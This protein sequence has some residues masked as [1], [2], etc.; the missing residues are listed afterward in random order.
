M[1]ENT[2]KDEMY[3]RRC[4]ELAEHGMGQV[5]PNPMVGSVIVCEDRIIGEGYHRLYG[6]PHAEVNAIES[7]K[8]KNLLKR[9]TL[10]VNLEP[11]AHHGKTPP[12]SVLIQQM[13][14]PR[15]VIGSVDSNPQVAGKG[16]ERLTKEGCNVTTGILEKESRRL[17]KRFYTFHEK[18]RPYIILKWAQTLDGLIDVIRTPGNPAQPTWITNDVCRVLVHKWRSEEMA[19]LAG[20]NTVEKDNP[21]LTVRHWSGN[22]PV[23]VIID[24]SLRLPLSLKVFNEMANTLI[25]N[26]EID[27]EKSNIRYRKINFANNV[28][29]QILEELYKQEVN[30]LIIEGGRNLI[31]SFINENLWDEA[32]VFIGQ[33]LFVKGVPSPE[34]PG[35]PVENTLVGNSTLLY[36]KNQ[37]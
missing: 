24:R 28:P 12:C 20:T 34:L 21:E 16:I 15:V 5:A 23:R 14:I 33:K 10:Y 1:L 29:A 27:K 18:K 7:V 8:D 22:N 36:Y 32:R 30:S 2:E 9:S 37:H 3:M 35:L 26:Q 6:G 13:G 11:C 4:L 17:N 19:I 31:Q 25:F